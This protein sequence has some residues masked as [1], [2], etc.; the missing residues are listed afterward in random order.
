MIK[1]ENLQN[2]STNKSP[3][4]LALNQFFQ[5][6]LLERNI[7]KTLSMVTDDIYSLGT[8]EDELAMNKEEFKTLITSEFSVLPNPIPYK[9]TNYHEKQRNESTFDCFCNVET[10]MELEKGNTVFYSTRLTASFQK[11]DD[12]YLASVL[13]MSEASTHQEESEFFPLRFVSMEINKLD[14][15]SQHELIKILCQTMPGGIIGHYLEEDFPFYVVNDAFL[16]L[17]GYTYDEFLEATQGKVART[18]YPDDLDA[19]YNCMTDS[20]KFGNQYE[21]EYRVITKNGSILWVYDIGR[22]IITSEGRAAIISIVIDISENMRIQNHLLEESIRDSLTGV[23]N[24]KGGEGFIT[25]ALHT[26]EPYVFLIMDIDKFK[27]VNDIYGHHQGDVLLQ[28]V[29]NQ[30]TSTFRSTDIILRLGG[31]E[32]IIFIHPCYKKEIVEQKLQTL[33]EQY[34][35]EIAK[36]YPLSNSTI[37]FG[38]VYG[39]KSSSFLE[40]YQI[41][42]K[43]LYEIKHSTKDAYKLKHFE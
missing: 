22:K 20:F 27:A 34:K 16:A 24:R 1:H 43:I 35:E 39:L 42:D 12:Q 17:L 31:D 4:F 15:T 2:E 8:G 11:I 36:H 5:H 23:Y 19:V 30:L 28:Y 32:F 33:R 13:H 18:I 37:S 26:P 41:S 6:Y 21:I 9:I 10:S 40:L 7:T 38:G 14:K 3:V 25:N 29:A